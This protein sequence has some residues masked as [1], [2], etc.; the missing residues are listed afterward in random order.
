MVRESFTGRLSGSLILTKKAMYFVRVP[1]GRAVKDEKCQNTQTRVQKRIHLE[2]HDGARGT[3][4]TPSLFSR[5][6]SGL[7]REAGGLKV[8]R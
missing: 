5:F 2:D 7:S 6:E 1:C 3:N 4:P 8:M